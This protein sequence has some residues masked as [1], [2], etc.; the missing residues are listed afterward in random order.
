MELLIYYKDKIKHF[1]ARS[2]SLPDGLSP[3]FNWLIDIPKEIVLKKTMDSLIFETKIKKPLL[4]NI[5][6]EPYLPPKID[7]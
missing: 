1:H 4:L 6:M 2:S 7:N 5:N 3:L